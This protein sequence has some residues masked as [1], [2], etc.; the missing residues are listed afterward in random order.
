VVTGPDGKMWMV[1][2]QKE[3][4]KVNWKRFV[5]IDPLWFDENGVI[6]T[7]VTRGTEEAAPVRRK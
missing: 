5:A 2:H 7:K 3:D 6:K 4:D 1:Y